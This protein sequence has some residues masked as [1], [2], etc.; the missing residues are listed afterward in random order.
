MEVEAGSDKLEGWD[1]YKHTAMY[2]INNLQGPTVYTQY[3]GK[4]I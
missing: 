4:R 1:P 2:K 3:F